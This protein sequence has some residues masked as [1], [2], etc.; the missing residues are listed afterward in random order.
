MYSSPSPA[1]A[2]PAL[3]EPAL[4]SSHA[5]KLREAAE[6]S[7]SIKAE[8]VEMQGFVSEIS[9]RLA[10]V[11]KDTKKLSTEMHAQFAMINA[12]LAKLIPQA[13][14]SRKGPQVKA[15]RQT[16]RRPRAQH[17][18]ASDSCAEIG[19]TTDSNESLETKRA[20]RSGR[21]N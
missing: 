3:S 11:S 16:E 2:V 6:T 10:A 4:G 12:T 21:Q 17:D 1:R 19:D 13:A 14:P 8:L 9:D 15:E 5:D 20:R 7:A 18:P